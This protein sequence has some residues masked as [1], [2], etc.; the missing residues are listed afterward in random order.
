MAA[1]VHDAQS[2]E[3]AI[4]SFAALPAGGLIVIL[5]LLAALATTVKA[6]FPI[7]RAAGWLLVPYLL[8]VAYATTLNIGILLLNP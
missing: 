6:F 7:S 8:W 1:K 2:I 5:L 3:S 4:A